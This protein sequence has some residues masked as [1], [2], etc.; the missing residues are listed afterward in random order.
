MLHFLANGKNVPKS[1]ITNV[2]KSFLGPS[3]DNS[4]PPIL[5]DDNTVIKPDSRVR[6]GSSSYDNCM[7]SSMIK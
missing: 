2:W 3:D 1:V 4:A 5:H 6:V 7:K